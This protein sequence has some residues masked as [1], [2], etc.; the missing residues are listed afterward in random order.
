MNTDMNFESP[1]GIRVLSHT[2]ME[3]SF[4]HTD[5][6]LA[7]INKIR[8]TAMENQERFCETLR[9]NP[10]QGVMEAHGYNNAISILG[11]RGS[12]K[13]SIIMTIQHIL[14]YGMNAWK[15][16]KLAGILPENIIMPIL[17]P[18]DFSRDQS[19]LSW[20][21][22]QLIKKGE[23][24]EQQIKNGN[25][26]FYQNNNVIAKWCAD[27]QMRPG[28]DPLHE[29]M[30]N[31]TSSFELRCKIDRNYASGDADHVFQYMDE[32]R[33]DSS[34]VL[35]MLKL[36][37]MIVD[38]YRLL[39]GNLYGTVEAQ[40][41][42]LIFFVIDD[43][44]LAPERSQEVLNL[45]LRYLQHPNL[46]VLC[47]WNQE[48]FQSHLCIDL[49]KNQN[50][51]STQNLNT[52][53]GYDDVFMTR[54]RQRVAALDSARRLA[55]D[56]MKKAFPPAL[57]YEIRGLNI[58][59]RAWFPHR[60]DGKLVLQN[61]TSFLPLIEETLLL[62]RG[63]E[64][65]KQVDFLHNA[66]GDYLKIY[67][68]IFDNKARGM[69]N[70]YRAFKILQSRILQWD[71][72][73]S[74]NLTADLVSLLDTVLFSNTH[75][76]PYRR[77]L[78]DLIRID[79]VVLPGK[80]NGEKTYEYYCNYKAVENVM[81]EYRNA[82]DS[83]DE[84]NLLSDVKY[85]IEREYNYFP[86]V[87]IDAYLLLNFMQNLIQFICHAP[88][89]EHG[90]TEFSNVLNKINPP[91]RIAANVD[92][93]L[94]CALALSGLE[95]LWLFPVT[96]DFRFNLCL[97]DAYEKNH[98]SDK[99]YDFTGSHSYCRLSR[100]IASL[101]GSGAKENN[102]AE[103]PCCVLDEE[104][105]G[106]FRRWVPEWMNSMESI[107]H[108]LCFTKSNVQRLAK[109]RS[110]LLQGMIESQEELR[111]TA[112]DVFPVPQFDAFLWKNNNR[113]CKVI[114]DVQ[115]D[116]LVN[117]LRYL[118]TVRRSFNAYVRDFIKKD[119]KN[120]KASYINTNTMLNFYEVFEPESKLGV[121]RCIDI[122]QYNTK[123]T[124]YRKM[125]VDDKELQITISLSLL[126]SIV[127]CVNENIDLLLFNLECRLQTAFL[128]AY[129]AKKTRPDQFSF[130][131]FASE[132]IK[133]YS[134]RWNLGSGF[135]SEFENDA[136]NNMMT[137][138]R[139]SFDY[140]QYS[141]VKRLATLGHTLGEARRNVYTD[142]V[143][144]LK[145]WVDANQRQF[146]EETFDQLTQDLTIL[147]N[148]IERIRRGTVVDTQIRDML[149][150]FGLS[151]AQMCAD[152]AYSD[153]LLED[154]TSSERN[155][156]TWPIVVANR[157]TFDIWQDASEKQKQL[158]NNL[159][160]QRDATLFS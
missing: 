151:I 92:D 20:V 147:Q 62:C 138:F 119:E 5:A 132:I 57:R 99:Q 78:R 93:L 86:Y 109:Y 23:E 107:F 155:S 160:P 17:V 127:D 97:L 50:V 21:I 47:G 124:K 56:N 43:L 84:D 114:T 30:D 64:D 135:W 52:N 158:R 11:S 150:S 133:E 49:L 3:C 144:S 123:L 67:M 91:V 39:Q 149:N 9:K 145:Q 126:N 159:K 100:L 111:N 88:R 76:V 129:Q 7:A 141:Q 94:S 83:I 55:M 125:S 31:L 66:Q 148:A 65:L 95:K 46:V 13:T 154:N 27:K 85:L 18:Q 116:D 115:L 36:I 82:L 71:R 14:T 10:D 121:R 128:R 117:M 2:M 68:R 98:F 70:V 80:E 106:N 32:V 79:C 58:E 48:L 59:Q 8:K 29:C 51:L 24:I 28:Y 53:F 16:E 118:D 81:K 137:I 54:Q 142:I 22:V 77:G 45:V 156:T 143:N 153:D 140:E 103:E 12:G 152:I 26:F 113:Y 104:R 44:D 1:I 4:Q 157:G 42:P 60:P 101:I 139:K 72:K 102:S 112:A 69:T 96:R 40:R 89:Y 35:D 90:G 108:T 19:L 37:S 146:S 131:L 34:L 122:S 87:I 105:L 15:E 25:A 110:L 38:Y 136:A 120:E 75:F 134:S 61:Q 130:L 63:D 73:M 41:E 74:L 33:R 6:V